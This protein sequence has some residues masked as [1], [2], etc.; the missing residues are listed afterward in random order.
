MMHPLHV[1][2]KA[3]KSIF[4]VHGHDDLFVKIPTAAADAQRTEDERQD[5][6]KF[7]DPM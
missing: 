2:T 4:K 6:L 1:D 3:Y 7:A 5:R